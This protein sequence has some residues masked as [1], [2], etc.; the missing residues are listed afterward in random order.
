MAVTQ[1]GQGYLTS[2]TE[3]VKLSREQQQADVALSYPDEEVPCLAAAL[4]AGNALEAVQGIHVSGIIPLMCELIQLNEH[5]GTEM[6]AGVLSSFGVSMQ[7][8]QQLSSYDSCSRQ[9]A[10]HG[11]QLDA[12]ISLCAYNV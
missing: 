7:E 3:R 4:S 1:A 10:G 8:L 12:D 5:V 6:S 11:V 9:K 2:V